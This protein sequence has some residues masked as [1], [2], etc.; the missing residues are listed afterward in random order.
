MQNAYNYTPPCPELDL[1]EEGGVLR[2]GPLSVKCADKFREILQSYEL[3]AGTDSDIRIVRNE[4]GASWV[5][6]SG[7]GATGYLMQEHG[8]SASTE[9]LD[10]LILKHCPADVLISLCGFYYPDTETKIITEMTAIHDGRTVRWSHQCDRLQNGTVTNLVSVSDPNFIAKTLFLP[11]AL[12]ANRD[13][14]FA[15][16]DQLDHEAAGM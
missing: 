3:S 10:P 2:F 8:I 16:I 13:W 7:L 12:V 11:A 4:R 5:V 1:N 15:A 6:A 14:P 9:E